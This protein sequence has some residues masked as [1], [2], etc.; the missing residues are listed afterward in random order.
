MR[1]FMTTQKIKF[2]SSS[3]VEILINSHIK[4]GPLT[5]R[6]VIS[7]SC[8]NESEKQIRENHSLMRI[9]IMSELKKIF[10]DSF[11]EKVLD[12]NC[13]PETL[14]K[15]YQANRSLFWKPIHENYEIYEPKF[16]GETIE[17][18]KKR[19]IEEANL[20]KRNLKEFKIEDK[21]FERI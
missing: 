19:I 4:K 17:I 7:L 20:F 18:H 14:I 12:F 8:L 3:D 1:K 21:K 2:L 5:I 10:L 13:D 9:K 15:F 6:K 16:N 11:S